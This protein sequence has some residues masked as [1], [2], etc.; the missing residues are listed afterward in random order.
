MP[1][2]SYHVSLGFT[3]SLKWFTVFQIA[4]PV[5]LCVVMLVSKRKAAPIPGR[6]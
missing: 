3:A 4:I 6:Q 2:F 5:L 1:D